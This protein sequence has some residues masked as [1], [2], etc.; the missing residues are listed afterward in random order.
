MLIVWEI[1]CKNPE[2]ILGSCVR[3]L[4]FEWVFLL[5]SRSL[6]LFLLG[7]FVGSGRLWFCGLLHVHEFLLMLVICFRSHFPLYSFAT[8]RKGV[9]ITGSS[10]TFCIHKVARFIQ[11]DGHFPRFVIPLFFAMRLV[12]RKLL[13]EH[14]VSVVVVFF[15]ETVSESA[16]VFSLKG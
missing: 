5:R 8:K 13:H 3:G 7:S 4:F 6:R 10:S 2:L 12:P 9:A 16:V 11:R 15:E 14:R 1:K